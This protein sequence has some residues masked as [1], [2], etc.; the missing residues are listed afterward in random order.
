LEGQQTA[1]VSG[2]SADRQRPAPTQAFNLAGRPV[3]HAAKGQV[4]VSNGKKELHK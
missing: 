3:T 1:H 4:V 2:L